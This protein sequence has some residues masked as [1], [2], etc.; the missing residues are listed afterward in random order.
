MFVKVVNMMPHS[1]SGE[2]NMDSEPSIAVNPADPRQIAASAFAPDPMLSGSGPIYVSNDG[3]D[4]WALNVVL[5][6]G[7]LTN[8]ITLRF[9]LAFQH[10]LRGHSPGVY[11]G[12]ECP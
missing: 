1:L 4:T 7:N 10:A 8:D 9:R 5:P 12:L 2:D 11:F 3:G 6:G